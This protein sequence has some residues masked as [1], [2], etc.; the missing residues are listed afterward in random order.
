M[1]SLVGKCPFTLPQG[2]PSREEHIQYTFS[3]AFV[4]FY[5]VRNGGGTGW[6]QVVWRASKG[7]IYCLL[8]QIPTKSL[9]HPKQKP[10][11]GG[12]LRH[13]SPNPLTG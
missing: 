10:R 7:V 12:G 8:D 6:D 1:Y 3:A 9:Y 5:A 11:R 13:L 2:T 4:L